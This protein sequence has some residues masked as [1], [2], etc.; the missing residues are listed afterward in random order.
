MKEFLKTGDKLFQKI[1]KLKKFVNSTYRNLNTKDLKTWRYF[2]DSYYYQGLVLN[3]I[4]ANVILSL[5]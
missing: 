1:T 5:L 4:F 3:K 2:L